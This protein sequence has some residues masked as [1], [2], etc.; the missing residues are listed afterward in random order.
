MF[1]NLE[2]C[3]DV[4]NEKQR[5]MAMDKCTPVPRNKS[6]YLKKSQLLF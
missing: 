1:Y 3:F 6:L 2:W 5:N 4:K